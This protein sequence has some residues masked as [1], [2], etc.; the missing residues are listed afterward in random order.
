VTQQE[1][2]LRAVSIDHL[3]ARRDCI[4]EAIRLL[5][6]LCLLTRRA[7]DTQLTFADPGDCPSHPRRHGPACKKLPGFYDR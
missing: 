3:S 1:L 4:G 2:G 7:A 6:E 5:D